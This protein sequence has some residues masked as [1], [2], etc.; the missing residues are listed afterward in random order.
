MTTDNRTLSRKL[1]RSRVTRRN[2][3]GVF[4]ADRIPPPGRIPISYVVN[5]DTADKPGEHWVGLFIKSRHHIYYFDSYAKPPNEYLSRYL[6]QFSKVTSNQKTFQAEESTV[7]GYYIL[8]FIYMASLGYTIPQIE[9]HL[10][11]YRNPDRFV[12]QFNNKFF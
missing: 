12:V 10:S 8:Y 7:C 2:F 3:G 11:G 5:T 4:A 9:T 6:S 1:K